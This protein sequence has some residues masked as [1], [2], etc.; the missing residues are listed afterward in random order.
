MWN[1]RVLHLYI[2]T[3][4]D[5][6]PS[7]FTPAL[8]LS[9][10]TVLWQWTTGF[11]YFLQSNLMSIFCA[12]GWRFS[13]LWGPDRCLTE[14]WMSLHPSII[15]FSLFGLSLACRVCRAATSICQSSLP[16][17]RLAGPLIAM[18][19]RPLASDWLLLGW[20]RLIHYGPDSSN[21]PPPN[22]GSRVLNVIWPFLSRSCWQTDSEGDGWPCAERARSSPPLTCLCGTEK[23]RQCDFFKITFSLRNALPRQG[24]KAA[25]GIGQLILTIN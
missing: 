13:P 18:L 5:R 2:L 6:Q 10:C 11:L 24:R 9:Y 17:C 22:T 14:W 16:R 1:G 7:V 15:G 20:P 4:V 12:Q 25:C 19:M 23:I 3:S 21:L 8:H